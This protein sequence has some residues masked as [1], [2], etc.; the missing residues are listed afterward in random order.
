LILALRLKDDSPV[1]SEVARARGIAY[2]AALDE[3]DG[4]PSEA[5]ELLRI[6]YRA[7]LMQAEGNPDGGVSATELPADPLRRR[8]I[9][10][11]RRA[12]LTLRQSQDIGDDAFHQIEE[13]LDR[14]ELSAQG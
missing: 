9:G 7:L 11:A 10:A 12:I 14:A 1:T 5:A 13:E 8:A 4:D 2:R 3:I 6:E